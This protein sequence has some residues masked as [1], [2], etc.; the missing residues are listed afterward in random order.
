MYV[1]SAFSLNLCRQLSATSVRASQMSES[2]QRLSRQLKEKSKTT[3]LDS[4][5]LRIRKISLDNRCVCIH[6]WSENVGNDRDLIL[7]L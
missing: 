1:S 2:D 7:S 6:V 5:T 4:Q 3:L